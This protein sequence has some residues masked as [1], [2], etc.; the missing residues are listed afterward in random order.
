MS[1]FDKNGLLS[2][3]PDYPYSE[4]CM[5]YTYELLLLTTIRGKSV[6]EFSHLRNIMTENIWKSKISDGVYKQHPD[7]ERL[8]PEEQYLSHDQFTAFSCFSYKYRDKKVTKELWK[9][10]L[11]QTFRMDTV[12][13][14]KPSWERIQHPRDII[15]WGYLA[16]NPICYLLMPILIPML[17][18]SCR[19][20]QEITSGKILWWVRINSMNKGIFRWTFEKIYDKILKKVYN[21]DSYMTKIFRIYFPYDD[22]PI[23]ELSR[24]IYG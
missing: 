12:N 3:K 20:P 16:G 18:L 24:I 15:F 14:D 5:L 21:T 17:I 19:E 2:P 9:E 7:Q 13:P 22:H 4:N 10:L 1:Y 11:R 8:G 6:Q 23:N